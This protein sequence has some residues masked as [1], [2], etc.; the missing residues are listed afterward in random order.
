[1]PKVPCWTTTEIWQHEVAKLKLGE[2]LQLS[3]ITHWC[4]RGVF[5]NATKIN[6]RWCIPVSDYD[7]ATFEK[8]KRGVKYGSG[9]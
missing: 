5:P 1:M 8:P 2:Q 9:N 6:N 3:T 4:S 7:P